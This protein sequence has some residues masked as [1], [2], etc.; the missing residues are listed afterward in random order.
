[1]RSL[2]VVGGDVG[3]AQRDRYGECASLSRRTVDVNH[4]LMQF[5]QFPH[6]GQADSGSLI[7]SRAHILDAVKALEYAVSLGFGDANAGVSHL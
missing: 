7:A 3:G 1:M 2:D 4:T 5:D 6:Q